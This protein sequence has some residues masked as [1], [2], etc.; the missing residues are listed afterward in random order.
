MSDAIQDSGSRS[1]M[2]TS[3]TCAPPRQA[4][5]PDDLPADDWS[6]ACPMGYLRELADALADGL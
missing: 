3:T 2:P 1:R 6:E 5:W 4:R